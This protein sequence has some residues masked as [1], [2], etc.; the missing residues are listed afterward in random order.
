ME[1]ITLGLGIFYFFIGLLI[2]ISI[3]IIF[4]NITSI[5]KAKYRRDILCALINSDISPESDKWDE[6]VN[7]GKKKKS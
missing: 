3:N 4:E 6:I 5:I 1:S 7:D 2:C